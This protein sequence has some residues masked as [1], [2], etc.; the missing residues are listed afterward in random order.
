MI[1][2]SAKD[3]VKYTESIAKQVNTLQDAIGKVNESVE[4]LISHNDY[5]IESLEKV[6][7]LC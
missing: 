7:K 1:N 6:K 2:P 3:F 5:I 4:G